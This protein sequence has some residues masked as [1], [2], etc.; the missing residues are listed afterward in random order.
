LSRRPFFSPDS[1]LWPVFIGCRRFS[2]T[3]FG[4]VKKGIENAE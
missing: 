4:G 1:L 3:V 2:A